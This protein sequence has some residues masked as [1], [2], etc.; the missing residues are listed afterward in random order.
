MAVLAL[1][2]SQKNKKMRPKSIPTIMK[3]QRAETGLIMTAGLIIAGL[4]TNNHIFYFSSLG[5]ILI[6]LLTP[7]ILHPFA[8][9]WFGM[10]KVMGKITSWILIILIFF[11][12]V[13]PVALVRRWSG[14]DNLNLKKF[15]KGSSSV[16]VERN[17]KYDRSDMVHLF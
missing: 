15:K 13:T 14:K 1:P 10:S 7:I 8:V 17:H 3:K 12:V 4:L 11:L 5:M 2:H 16:F 6:S 9:S